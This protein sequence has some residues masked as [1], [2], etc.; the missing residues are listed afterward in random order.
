MAR[1]GR[2]FPFRAH[3]G[4]PIVT[5]TLIT[6]TANVI[7]TGNGAN[8]RIAHILPGATASV[9]ITG[10]AANMR[11]GRIAAGATG[12]VIITGNAATAKIAHILPGAAGSVVL[13]GNASTTDIARKLSGAAGSVVITGNAAT[14]TYTPTAG[15]FTLNAAT[16]TLTI[17]G[18][19]AT[20]TY[21]AVAGT[22]AHVP[23]GI[24]AA[25]VEEYGTAKPKKKNKKLKIQ[26]EVITEITILNDPEKVAAQIARW[27]DEQD[28]QDI[29]AIME[30]LHS[31][32]E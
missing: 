17:T 8:V 25:F 19:A 6:V 14:L 28:E 29:A 3:I 4:K 26:P 9:I 32:Y 12:S 27:S 18:N 23:Q 21:G 31:L 1:S 22:P 13:T 30:L 16:G 2:T 7:I 15:A 20:L 5:K 24:V 10:N 11:V